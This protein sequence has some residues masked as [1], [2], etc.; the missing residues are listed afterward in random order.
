MGDAFQEAAKAA[1]LEAKVKDQ[2][3]QLL[4]VEV[5]TTALRARLRRAEP[6]TARLACCMCWCMFSEER[7]TRVREG[8]AF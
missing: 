8:A 6:F 2:E 5:K 4:E 7:T 1:Q 3:A